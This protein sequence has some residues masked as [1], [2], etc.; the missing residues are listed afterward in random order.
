MNKNIY[1]VGHR[2]PDT[3]SVVSAAAYAKLKQAQG[4]ADCQAIRAGKLS[5]QTEYIFSRFGVPVPE[6]IPTSYQRRITI[7]TANLSPSTPKHPCGTRWNRC[8]KA[9]S[10]LCPSLMITA[11]I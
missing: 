6:Y 1:V 8:K 4:M 2:N 5:P 11:S 10:A 3:D 9:A 7:Y